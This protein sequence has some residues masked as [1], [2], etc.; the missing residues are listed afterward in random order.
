M[1][2]VVMVTGG[3]LTNP[4]GFAALVVWTT[5]GTVAAGLYMQTWRP[6]NVLGGLLIVDG[7]LV[8]L[9]SFQ[10]SP[11][12][13]LFAIGLL[14]EAPGTLIVFFV[15]LAYPSGVLGRPGRI[16]F[17]AASAFFAFAF[18]PR[19]FVTEP[20]WGGSPLATCKPHCPD[21]PLLLVHNQT[22]VDAMHYWLPLSRLVAVSAVAV[23]LVLQLR[24]AS[25]PRQRMLMPV[26]ALGILWILPLALFG[27]VQ[28]FT[29]AGSDLTAKVGFGVVMA[30]AMVPAAFLL[31][32]LQARAFSGLALQQMLRRF[33]RTPTL[34][35]RERVI[36]RTLDDPRLRLAFWLPQSHVYVDAAGVPVE[37]PDPRSG[38]VWTPIRRGGEPFAAIIH[39]AALA[40]DPELVDAAG[41][42]LVL[43]ISSRRIEADLERSLDELQRSRRVLLE[44]D[45]ADRRRLERDLHATAQQHLVALR[46]SLE[47]ARE[48]AL[49][50]TALA[51]RLASL[52]DGLDQALIDLR[53]IA[54]D[55]YSPLLE[56]AGLTAALREAARQSPRPLRL[57]LQDVGRLPPDVESCIW[58]CIHEALTN[59][60]TH[61]GD[62]TPRLRLSRDAESVSFSVGDDGVGFDPET[63]ASGPGLRRIVERLAAAGGTASIVS[64]PGRGTLVS[65]SVPLAV[66]H[67]ESR[68]PSLT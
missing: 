34:L 23:A 10:G 30:R 27:S 12:P 6:G 21:N 20:V 38:L 66:A 25:Q 17:A 35:A 5:V 59:A 7:F 16:A 11:N 31:A 58:V 3:V 15:L 40:D 51:E 26:A 63:A 4:D 61:A 8:A 52:G 1:G 56:Q 19:L 48:R 49:S 57:D 46:V 60:L 24:R 68:E 54:S 47:L 9:H 41:R 13:V 64:A 67:A 42:A 45:A 18:I 29:A 2:V 37:R 43:A 44:A 32:P 33:E 50:D 14:V 39:D 53:R 55:I 28:T 62:V 65:G 22:V 36:A